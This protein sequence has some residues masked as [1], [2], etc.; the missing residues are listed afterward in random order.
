MKKIIDF[1]GNM[2][3]KLLLSYLILIIFN[4]SL[5]GWLF[6]IFTTSHFFSTREEYLAAAADYF[7]KFVAANMETESEFVGASKFFLRQN[8]EKMDY[9]LVVTDLSGNIIADSRSLDE[10]LALFSDSINKDPRVKAALSEGKQSSWREMGE[11]YPMIYVCFPVFFETKIIGAVKL[12]MSTDDVNAL[13]KILRDYF[14]VTFI[15]SSIAAL[16]LGLI[17]VRNIMT[18][19]RKIRDMASEIS[20]GNFDGRLNYTAMDELGDLSKTINKMAE[21][22][23]KFEQTRNLFLANISHEL[24]T[25]LTI[26]KGFTMTMAGDP[27]TSDIQKHYLDTINKEADRLT[28]LVN[29]LLELSKI[30]TGRISLKPS[31]CNVNDFLSS[32]VFQMESRA[33][34]CG[35]VLSFKPGEGVPDI[36]I[37]QD[38]IKEV[39]INLIDN[40]L[41]YSKGH[42]ELPEVIVESS[43][44]NNFVE[45]SVKDTGPGISEED[46]DKVFERF[47]RGGS[48]SQKVEGV[49]LGLAI[50]REITL[51]HN[52]NLSVSSPKNTGCI[53]TVSLPIKFV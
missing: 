51:A 18:P 53:F 31:L 52:G 39:M 40:G 45:I 14:I 13:S 28:R 30:R 38:K 34:D 37:D 19:V 16:C 1:F 44:T 49:G 11:D 20:L 3:W 22:L 8:W 10:R 42:G 4:I 21:D 36:F 7:V 17:F 6:Y 41:K 24:K 46:I 50:A 43:F 47:F 2:R 12:G 29:E 32:I 33:S 25:P 35:C 23:K 5:M 9:E 26:I 15:L 27:E 48:R